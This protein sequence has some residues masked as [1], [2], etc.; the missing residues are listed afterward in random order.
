VAS[1]LGAA[2]LSLYLTCVS[3]IFGLNRYYRRSAALRFVD[4]LVPTR[5]P[6]FHAAVTTQMVAEGDR[7][8]RQGRL[9][10][11]T[12]TLRTAI[13]RAPAHRE[14][15][16]RLSEV[17]VAGNDAEGARDV[18]L[19]GVPFHGDDPAFLIPLF[20]LLFLRQEDYRA[21]GLARMLLDTLPP[22]PARDRVAAI[23]A[24]TACFFRGNYDQAEDFLRRVPGVAHSREGR[25]LAAKVDAERGYRELALAGLRALAGELPD[26]AEIHAEWVRQLRGTG[27][28]DEARRAAL[29]YQI[30]HPDAVTAQIELVRAY[31][32]AGD[33][34]HLAAEVSR[35]LHEPTPARLLALAE[36]AAQSRNVDLARRIAAAADA[37]H[38]PLEPH[39]FLIIEALLAA[40]DYRGASDALTALRATT[41]PDGASGA[42]V[43]SLHALASLG[44]GEREAAG[45]YL[46]SFLHQPSL[47]AENLLAVA[48][49][50]IDL[51]ATDFA[52]RVLVRAMEADPRNQAALTRLVQVE[53]ELRRID[54]LPRHLRSLA[55]MRKPAPDVLR[56]A[57]HHL[58]SDLF[59]F[60][61]DREAALDAVRIA[62]E[63]HDRSGA[64]F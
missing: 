15:R 52:W 2:L 56:V 7:L 63:Q 38:V 57:R 60:S 39:R 51:G 5:W 64:Q 61:A 13:R 21:L 3:T 37:A 18:L 31:A 34:A 8:A 42:L 32:D 33:E 35:M 28:T 6:Q 11:A 14:A 22:V 4:V 30:G 20:Q 19:A 27:R 43:A 10:E 24:A 44:L 50:M 17:L 49:A 53:I 58:G 29:A 1:L 9:H 48:N 36:F 41:S 62:L 59:L 55:A 25:L 45:V 40:R 12:L 16:L 47:R 23:A 26:D 54:D 46:N